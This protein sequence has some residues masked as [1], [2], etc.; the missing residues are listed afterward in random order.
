[1]TK[2]SSKTPVTELERLESE[3]SSVAFDANDNGRY[4]QAWTKDAAQRAEQIH[5]QIM[6]LRCGRV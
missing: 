5:Q 6:A 2:D 3:F 4:G 1:M